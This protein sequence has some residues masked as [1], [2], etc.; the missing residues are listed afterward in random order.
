MLGRS[1]N[2]EKGKYMSMSPWIINELLNKSNLSEN[3]ITKQILVPCLQVISMRSGYSLRDVQ[4]TGG[5]SEKGAD[6]QYYEIVGPDKYR[7]YTGIQV[8][9]KDITQGDATQLIIQG[10]QA[11]GKDVIDPSTGIAHRIH[12]WVIAATGEIKPAAKDEIWKELSRHGKLV[13]FWDGIKL[14]EMILD[15]FYNEFTRILNVDPVLA[16]SSNIII[17]WW[18]PDNP[19]AVD[20]NFVSEEWVKLDLSSSIPPT[21]NGVYIT[22]T[23]LN[24]NLPPVLCAFRSSVDD[25]TIESFMSQISPYLLHLNVGELQIE[26]RIIGNKRAVKITTRGFRFGR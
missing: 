25:V 22:I 6:I 14:S 4:F 8:K 24:E 7:F 20:E 18:D 12:R 11:F 2:K 13:S 19:P 5:V 17:Q 21:A 10:T 26:G 15:N 9:K 1:S 16:G 23:P 3:E